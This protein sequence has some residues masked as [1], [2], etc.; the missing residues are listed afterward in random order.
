MNSEYVFHLGEAYVKKVP[1]KQFDR[2]FP[3]TV[4]VYVCKG[5]YHCRINE[6]DIVINEGETLIV[7][8]NRYH[9]I[10]MDEGGVLNWA[11]ITLSVNGKELTDGYDIPDKITG[12]ISKKAGEY[13]AKLSSANENKDENRKAALTQKYIA[14][15]YDIILSVSTKLKTAK[16]LDKIKTLIEKR[17]GDKYTAKYLAELAGISVRN[18]ENQ[19]KTEYGITPLKYLNECRIK[20]AAFL[21]ASGKKVCETAEMTGYYDAYHFSKQFKK[22]MG[23]SPSEYAKTHTVDV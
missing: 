9:H 6:K 7:S 2:C 20:Y 23:I 17:P 21:L 19:F 12:D 18:L 22:I 8:P 4:M 5:K 14:G 15:L 1:H 11:H 10:W 13:L 16:R 3:F